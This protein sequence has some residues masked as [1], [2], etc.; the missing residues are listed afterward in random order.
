M[1]NAFACADG[2]PR[3]LADVSSIDALRGAVWIDLEQPGSDEIERVRTATGLHV[4]TEADVNEI[5]TSSRLASRD[6]VLYLSMPLI[7]MAE[8]GPTGVAAGFVVA[9]DRL[10]TVR[11]APSRIFDLYAEQMPRGQSRGDAGVH[12][13]VG[14]M[15][16]IVDRQADALEQLRT[17][18]DVLSHAIF[19]MGNGQA[20]GRKNEDATLRRTLGRSGGSAT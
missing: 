18:L 2:R 3:R 12:I 20:G 17:E 5:E 11:F 13:F 6:G 14:L 8:S 4:P 1:L 9:P 16:A 19:G 7:N 10:I 15:E